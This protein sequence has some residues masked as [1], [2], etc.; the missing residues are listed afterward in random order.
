MQHVSILTYGYVMFGFL[1][2]CYQTTPTEGAYSSVWGATMPTTVELLPPN[3]SFIYNWKPEPA[4]EYYCQNQHATKQLWEWSE[5][6]VQ[7][8]SYEASTK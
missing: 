4:H 1:V 8:I 2:Q 7:W 5:S 6:V 3:V